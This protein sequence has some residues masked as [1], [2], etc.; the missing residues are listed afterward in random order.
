MFMSNLLP[1]I[2]QFFQTML[3]L[4]L[5]YI[6]S[7]TLAGACTA[8]VAKQMGDSTAEYAG[9]LT[10]D[11]LVH[12]DPIGAIVLVLL[13]FGWGRE[14]PIDIYAIKQPLRDLKILVTY[15]S[16]TILHILLIVLSLITFTFMQAYAL[17]T[18]HTWENFVAHAGATTKLAI[19]CLHV[20]VRLNCGL[21]LLRF[22]QS[23]VDLIFIPLKVDDDQTIHILS[24]LTTFVILF[25]LG[26]KI[27]NFL[28]Q[29]SGII[30]AA[31]L[32][33]FSLA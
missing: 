7:V 16:S 5:A 29:L 18:G 15:Y 33:L 3:C 31:I 6:V 27:Q 9:Y 2:V 32:K 4:L 10:L 25:F 30:S 1:D 14:V 21:G 8:W 26:S 23:T 12:I 24:L 28:F 20:F 19:L 17:S 13:K 22:I 11:P